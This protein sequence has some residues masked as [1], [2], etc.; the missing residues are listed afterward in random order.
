[1]TDR[2]EAQGRSWLRFLPLAILA[3]VSAAVVGSGALRQVSLAN[4]SQH[5]GVLASLVARHPLATL[6]AYVGVYVLVIL[7]CAPGPFVLAIAGGFLFGSIMGGVAA[8]AAMLAGGLTV[9]CACRTAF[10]DWAA[11]RAGPTLARIEAGFSRNAFSYL[12]ALRLL[13]GA[14]FFMVNLAAGFARIRVST[15]LIATLVGSS[16]SAFILASLGAGLRHA[17][18]GEARLDAGLAARPDIALPLAALAVLALAPPLW[19]AWRRRRGE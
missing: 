1:M 17:L 15:F 13:P 14:P 7:A 5:R 3:A 18:K 6:A 8:M 12:V 19:R 10:G 16:P 4:L 11:H 2:A 9:F